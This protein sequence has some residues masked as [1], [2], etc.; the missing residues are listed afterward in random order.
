[1]LAR[2]LNTVLPVNGAGLLI[3]LSGLTFKQELLG[4]SKL[5]FD[6]K[7]TKQLFWAKTPFREKNSKG[8]KIVLCIRQVNSYL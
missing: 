6:H 3:L 5:P 2:H 8:I 1:L 7:L 4:F